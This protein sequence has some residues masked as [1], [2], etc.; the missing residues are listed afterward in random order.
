M[1]FFYLKKSWL[2]VLALVLLLAS[3]SLISNAQSRL[4]TGV[5]TDAGNNETLPG[6]TVGIKGTTRG[7]QTD[8]KGAF[9]LSAAPNEIL[10]FSFIGYASKEVPAGSAGTLNVKLSPAK[11]NLDEVVV[12]GYGQQ[13]K[14]TVT[15]AIATVDAHTFQDRGPTNNPVANLQGEVPGV[16]VTRTSAQPGRE[17]WN[18][19]IRGA[20]S[21]NNQDPL[22]V[23]DGVALNNNNELNSIN[24]NDIENISFLKDAAAAIYGARAAFGVVLITTKRGKPGQMTIQYDPSVSEKVLGLQ[25]HTVDLATWANGAMQALTNDNYGVAPTTYVWYQYAQFALGNLGKVVPA[26]AIPGYNGSAITAGLTYNGLPVPTL[27]DVK[28]FDFTNTKMSDVLW[29]RATS[30]EHNLSISGG[31]DKNVYRFSL[32]YL[33]DGSQ[34]K[35]GTNGNQRYNIRLNEDYRF[36]NHFSIT[37]N[38]SLERNDIQQPTLYSFGSYSALGTSFQPGLPALTISG[39]PYEW[40]GVASPPG[41]LRDGGVNYESNTRILLNSTLNFNFLK[42]FKA[43]GTVGYNTWYQDDRVQT[44]QVQ[45]YSY[46][47]TNLIATNPSAGGTN[48][49]GSN[50]STNYY[51]QNVTDPYYNLIG[52]LAYTNSFNKV[53]NVMLMGGASYERDEYD[54]WNARTFNLA[55]DDVASLGLGLSSG[56]AGYVTDG[57]TKNHYALGSY[58]GR[59]TYDYKGKYLLEA[60]GRYDGSSKFIAD[61][62]WKSFYGV[63]LGWRIAEESFVKKLNF[64]DDLKLRASYGTSGNQAGIGLY[65]YL[66]S[67]NVGSSNN[68]IGSTIATATTTTGSLVSLN[69]TWETVKKAN[70]GLDYSIFKGKLSGSVDVFQNRNENMLVS[71]TYPGTLGASAPQSNSGDLKTWGWEAIVTYRDHIGKVKFSL[72]GNITDS[73]NKLVHYSGV[74]LISGGYNQTVEGYPLGSYFGLKYGGKLQSQAQVDAYNNYYAPG[75]VINTIGLPAA[76]PLANQAGK[77]TGLRPGDNWFQDVNHDG[78][79]TAGTSNKDLGDYVYLGSDVPRYTFGFN[80]GAQWKGFDFYAIFQGVGKRTIFRGGSANNWRVPFTSIFQMQTNSWV[81]NVWSP[82]TPNAYYPNLHSA[83]NN[84]INNYNYQASSWSVENGAYLRLKNVVLGY[85]LPKSLMERTKT[86][87]SVRIYLAGSDLWELTGIHD[88][89]DPETTRTATGNERYP[90]YRYLTLGA[91]IVF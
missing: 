35:W 67:L 26:T 4:I 79:L 41:L 2:G 86:F 16:V 32:G 47:D 70:L 45:L 43:T 28:E 30:T 38:I 74:S 56:N 91:N 84:G 7:T 53:H 37:N 88:G 72:S 14:A 85:T 59:F 31:G 69:R 76:T 8:I 89:W 19:Q 46:Y 44:K 82:Q 15:G 62:R 24:P 52:T 23:L 77:F 48:A 61:K 40:G 55:S 12:V 71:V 78:K 66:Q 49:S 11:N 5:V 51:R 75:G 25:P 18:F 13:K 6:V 21:V 3:V 80:M 65:D 54:T 68:L 36:S 64:F 90:F 58:F 60:T 34:L 87:S 20:T 9:K 57:E 83:L 29:G 81:G 22:V 33:N 42:H 50:L 10:V 1:S 73:Q 63:S 27:G 17:N 39:R